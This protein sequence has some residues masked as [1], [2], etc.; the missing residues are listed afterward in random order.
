MNKFLRGALWAGL[1]VGLPVIGFLGGAAYQG[2]FTLLVAGVAGGNAAGPAGAATQGSAGV[3]ARKV[4][5][6]TDTMYNPPYIS[7]KPGKSPMGMDLT[8]V[9][10][11]E[12]S[13][14]TV[15]KVDPV[16]VQNMGVRVAKVVR[17]DLRTTLRNVG[18]FSEPE[19]NNLEI[20]LRVS[21]WI[22][23]LYANQEG[24][25][26]K[27]GDKLFD[28]F[29]PELTAAVDEL[30]MAR[31]A[32]EHVS[33]DPALRDSAEAM[34]GASRRKL[35]LAGLAE[36]QIDGLAKLDKSPAT[37]SFVSPREG[38]VREK[39][40]VEGAAVKSGD[41]IMRIA[42]RST[43]WL[44]IQVYEQQ[45]PLVKPGTEAEAEVTAVPGKT[46]NGKVDF[47]YPHLD[48]ASRTATARLVFANKDHELREG[49]YAT[50]RINA[51][52]A[53]K[54]LL[55]P[56]ETLLDSGDRQIVFLS[57]GE[58]HFSP[59]KV[60]VGQNGQNAA[61]P[62]EDVV[63]ILTG[64]NGDET[65]VTS[66]QFLLDSESRRQEAIAKHL[67]ARLLTPAV[68]GAATGATTASA[69][70]VEMNVAADKQVDAVVRAYLE[71]AKDLGGEKLAGVGI[72]VEP[73]LGAATALADHGGE[74]EAAATT[75]VEQAKAMAGLAADK[76]RE[77]FKAVSAAVI[78]LVEKY[79]PSAAAAEKGGG[80]FRFHCPMSK[81][82]WLAQ[83]EQVANPYYDAAG[84]KTCGELVGRIALATGTD[85]GGK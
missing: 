21:G 36:G 38:H 43:M 31:K 85:G 22:Q 20:N 79:P 82:D 28:L 68:G 80:I 81:A 77:G 49:M 50:V 60:T 71:L 42:D 47:I 75:I 65:V 15:V 57:E 63:E 72:E 53:T 18:V 35:L 1:L 6:W 9:Y 83:T 29:S 11:D 64:L 84:M 69:P 45:L 24:M 59:R 55:V 73:L 62:D 7:D 70:A 10:E 23:K 46:F 51:E 54:A 3:G 76:K 14:G 16:V 12:V 27:A 41:K 39:A 40:V 32:M 5:Y 19:Q 37:I 74:K 66:G 13:A 44:L 30:I 33:T 25:A 58:G 4:L 56:R 17:G 8:P 48:M 67:N 61:A 78:S 52:V 34:L 26:V 2:R